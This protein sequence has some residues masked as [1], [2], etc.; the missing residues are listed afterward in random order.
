MVAI[1]KVIFDTV[2]LPINLMLTILAVFVDPA[3]EKVTPP[4]FW[5]AL[6][7][8]TV[9]AVC[10]FFEHDGRHGHMTLHHLHLDKKK[11]E[12]GFKISASLCRAKAILHM[13]AA[14]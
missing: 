14:A 8:V 10:P 13:K 11:L 7:V 1:D 4:T 2:I 3:A 6:A 12:K 5:A 9:A